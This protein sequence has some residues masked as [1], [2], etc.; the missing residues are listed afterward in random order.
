LL[1]KLVFFLFLFY[2]GND[3]QTGIQHYNDRAVNSINLQA[4]P[5]HIE[6]S[7]QIFETFLKEK[8]GEETAGFY[9]LQSLI[10]KGRFVV[11]AESEKKAIFNKAVIKGTELV[12]LYPRNA[13]VRFS[14]VTAI[15]LLAELNGA[16]KSAKEGVLKNILN[17]TQKLIETDSLY[18]YCAGWKILGILNY[19]SPVIPL[20][21]TWPD[22]RNAIK[23][24]GKALKYFP[25]DLANNYYYA[26]ALLSI[27]DK[28]SAKIYFNLVLK[29]PSRKELFLED[30]FIKMEAKKQLQKMK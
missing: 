9:Y 19:K 26:E 18:N 13:P 6:K 4:D 22:K 21:L 2:S 7:I 16:M 10:F 17:H 23:L 8:K 5:T 20:V 15:G 28:K 12:N 11:I 25:A 1:N 3:L 30:E 27:G 14:L 24:V 29:L